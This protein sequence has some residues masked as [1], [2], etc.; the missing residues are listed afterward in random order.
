MPNKKQ[1]CPEAS[2]FACMDFNYQTSH[3]RWKAFIIS[4]SVS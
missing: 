4:S 3:I 1:G 2:L